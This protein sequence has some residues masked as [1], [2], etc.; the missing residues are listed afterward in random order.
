MSPRKPTKPAA[1][2]RTNDAQLVVRLP[3]ALIDELDQ[4]A[5]DELP[6]AG[7]SRAQ[8]VRM[9]LTKALADARKGRRR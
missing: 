3:Q 2:S 6:G 7:L 8:V 5:A 9:L 4:Y 1:E